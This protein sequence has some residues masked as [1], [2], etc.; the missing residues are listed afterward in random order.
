MKYLLDTCVISELAKP[1][2][3][4][5]V[6]DFVLKKNEE[7]LYISTLTIGELIK[8]IEKLPES[9]KKNE[10]YAWVH[11]DLKERF[12]NRIIDINF[13][14]AK[15]WGKI[16]AT[17]EKKGKPMPAIDSLIAATGIALNLIVVTRNVVDMVE[18]GVELLNLWE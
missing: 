13:D 10:L 7:T 16:Q 14:I 3:D 17:A 8:G 11:N 9:A 18:S 12:G 6:V 15:T 2:A 1:K 4:K 5:R